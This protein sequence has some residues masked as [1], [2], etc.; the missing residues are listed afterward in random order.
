MNRPFNK[1]GDYP[2]ILEVSVKDSAMDQYLQ[3]N[4]PDVKVFRPKKKK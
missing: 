1:P 4:Y 2:L 3:K